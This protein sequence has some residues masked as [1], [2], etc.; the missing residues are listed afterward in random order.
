MDG[1][2]PSFVLTQQ[3]DGP[4]LLAVT[5]SI[6]S[7]LSSAELLDIVDT[8]PRLKTASEIFL[9]ISPCFSS[10]IF[11]GPRFT[12]QAEYV[13]CPLIWLLL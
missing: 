9:T 7:W 4:K 1:G 11:S 10:D 2:D 5:W 3:I 13:F 6:Y 8:V 12:A